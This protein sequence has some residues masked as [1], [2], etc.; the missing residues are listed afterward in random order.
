[1]LDSRPAVDCVQFL[2][3]LQGRTD[4]AFREE[5]PGKIMH[6]LRRGELAALK[7]IPHTPYYGAVD[8]TGAVSAARLR[9]RHVDRR[10]RVLRAAARAHRGRPA[11]D[12]RERRLRRRRLRRVS[13]ALPRGAREPGLARRPRCD[14]APR[15]QRGPGPHRPGR[16]AGLRLLRQ[17]PPGESL[18]AA[19]RRRALGAPAGRIAGPQAA[20]N[21]RFWMADEGYVA[22]ALDGEK[23]QV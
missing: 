20:F 8:S 13:P 15:R 22:M 7:A 11:L 6:E 2:T 16:V 3:R 4:S 23:R 21:E 18:R 5:E 9:G 1:M 17:A 10:P 14:R 19:R 12:R